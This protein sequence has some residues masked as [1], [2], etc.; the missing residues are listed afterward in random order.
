MFRFLRFLS[1]SM[2]INFLLSGCTYDSVMTECVTGVLERSGMSPY[3]GQKI[4]GCIS[5]LVEYKWQ[6][7]FYFDS[8]YPCIDGMMIPFNCAGDLLTNSFSD[9]VLNQYWQERTIVEIVGIAE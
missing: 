6:E 7:E 4:E 3:R 5:Y 8:E 1:I 2:F 9:P